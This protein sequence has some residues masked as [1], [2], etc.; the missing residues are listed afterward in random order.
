MAG[1][2]GRSIWII[3]AVGIVVLGT[4]VVFLDWKSDS[5]GSTD[6]AGDSTLE[7]DG[8]GRGTETGSSDL[9]S[10]RDHGPEEIDGLLAETID[11][12]RTPLLGAAVPFSG[13][14]TDEKTGEPITR[15]T[16]YLEG[17]VEGKWDYVIR[18]VV[19]NEE[20]RFDFTVN[21]SD[22]YCFMIH[23]M[24][25]CPS[26]RR[27]IKIP[28]NTGITNLLVTLDPGIQLVG[29]VVDDMTGNPISGAVAGV[30]RFNRLQ[31]LLPS[32]FTEGCNY[33]TTDVDGRFAVGGAEPLPEYG[34]PDHV[35]VGASHPDYAT[36]SEWIKISECGRI[37]FRL[38]KGYCI[39]GKV[40]DDKGNLA[41]GIRIQAQYKDSLLI[42]PVYS[43]EKGIYRTTPLLPGKVHIMAYDPDWA[44]HAPPVFTTEEKEVEIVDG[45]VQ[46]D[47]GPSPDHLTWRGR[48]LGFDGEPLTDTRIYLWN[49][50]APVN[51]PERLGVTRTDAEGRFEFMKLYP[52]S[53]EV[54][55][56]YPEKKSR[57]KAGVHE[58]NAPGIV[59]KDIRL[60]A[61]GGSVSGVV[62][63]MVTDMPICGPD[64]EGWMLKVSASCLDG[65]YRNNRST[66]VNRTDGTFR[67]DKL[68]AGSYVITCTFAEPISGV[69]V[70]D[71]SRIDG[72]KLRV[73]R[74]G[75][76][77]LNLHGFDSEERKG[78]G[79]QAFSAAGQVRLIAREDE[80]KKE[81]FTRR[82]TIGDFVLR[83]ASKELGEVKKQFVILHG[84]TTDLTV[85]RSELSPIALNLEV[86]GRLSLADGRPVP[87]AEILFEPARYTGERVRQETSSNENGAFFLSG[88][89][90]GMW[91]LTCRTPDGFTFRFNNVDIPIHV[92]S[93]FA[94]ELTV[95][96]G[97]VNG[98]LVDGNTGA[99]V[100][101]GDVDWLLRVW[102]LGGG[103]GCSDLRRRGD[104]RFQVIGIP[105]GRYRLSAFVPGYKSFKTDS[106]E[107]GAGK[108]I[109]L[110]KLALTPAGY[111]D[112]EVVDRSGLP[113]ERGF[114]AYCDGKRLGRIQ[115]DNCRLSPSRRLFYN[116]PT[117][118]VLIR[119]EA[120]GYDAE[121]KEIV[122]TPG[123][124]TR[125][126]MVVSKG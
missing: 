71:G 57:T 89:W 5:D 42:R 39:F 83:C 80:D 84:T 78:I 76:L 86:H 119:V 17:P 103:I 18:E 49:P 100:D 64:L 105:Q 3:A 91:N 47:F 15:F 24:N 13:R 68:F 88:L 48:L 67:F 53:F 94:L 113:L 69:K 37:E 121:E 62:V 98:F 70:T 116:L 1:T 6:L 58:F 82:L 35:I 109:D 63:D 90:S 25:H 95:P 45:D 118:K 28:E 72:L 102:S 66:Q 99:P 22:G 21:P 125:L 77:C 115:E 111:L 117:G 96:S 123:K 10:S 93:P 9:G 97:C 38:Q 14:V 101:T 120:Y 31:D 61:T 59:E 20:G 51:N 23:S 16:V 81:T 50:K 126:Q 27:G 11:E 87:G 104:A 2:K 32:G 41:E 7:G 124:R 46:V 75:E 92:K 12:E 29:R 43:N 26:R 65:N 34:L 85:N 122:L 40:R 44:V 110:G 19:E 79:I 60:A 30:I 74:T 108:E 54:L 33:T 112:L 73:K 107:M 36:V 114:A 4:A 55:A 52:G 56:A 8:I 106:F